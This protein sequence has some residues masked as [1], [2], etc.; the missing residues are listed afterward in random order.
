MMDTIA[1]NLQQPLINSPFLQL[2]LEYNLREVVPI[3]FEALF[4][5]GDPLLLDGA[6]LY[7]V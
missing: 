7:L 5:D 4:L 1:K 2:D 6:P 3:G